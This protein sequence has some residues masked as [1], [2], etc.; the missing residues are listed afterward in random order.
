[1]LL[2]PDKIYKQKEIIADLTKWS[3]FCILKCT[4]YAILQNY[5]S[6]FKFWRKKDYLCIERK[7]KTFLKNFEES[8]QKKSIYKGKF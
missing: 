5:S 6:I 4:I 7:N 3:L 1:M 2:Y 8:S